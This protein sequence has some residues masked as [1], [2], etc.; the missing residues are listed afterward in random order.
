M[1]LK[2]LIIT[3][4]ALPILAASAFAQPS[5]APVTAPPNNP[6]PGTTEKENVST[7]NGQ[8]V[9]VGDR[10]KFIYNV[11]KYNVS[12]NPL[13]WV[14]GSYGVGV[15]Y[16]LNDKMAIRG[17][18]GFWAPVEE[19][20][21]GDSGVELGVAVPIYF[22][23]IYSGLFVEPG[24]ISRTVVSSDNTNSSTTIFGPQFLVGWHWIWDSGLNMSM[25]FGAGR[26]WNTNKS[27]SYYANSDV[28]ESKIFPAGYWRFGYAF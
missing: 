17:D 20:A 24:I 7:M 1:K 26:N 25:A 19:S 21:S 4:V 16:T 5:G 12:T 2:T 8:L 6:P 11:K 15:S 22:R 27:D 18:I 10:N 13:M 23:K 14:F 9:P 3:A 28:Y